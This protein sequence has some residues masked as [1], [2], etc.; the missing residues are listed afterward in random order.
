MP[1]ATQCWFPTLNAALEAEGLTR[2]WPLGLNIGYDQTADCVHEGTYI[3]V[4]RSDDGRY[5][6]P[7][8]PL[9]HQA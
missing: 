7:P 2:H 4:Y 3:S 8:H 5:E 9:C 1:I 6:H